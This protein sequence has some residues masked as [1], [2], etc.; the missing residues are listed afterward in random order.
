VAESENTFLPSKS[1][2]VVSWTSVRIVSIARPLPRS[3]RARQRNLCCPRPIKRLV[4]CR[5]VRLCWPRCLS[6]SLS[7]PIL[8]LRPASNTHPSHPSLDR[9]CRTGRRLGGVECDPRLRARGLVRKRGLGLVLLTRRTVLL[10][11]LDIP[12]AVDERACVGHGHAAKVG[13]E[14]SACR[15]AR[16][17]AL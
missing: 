3:W 12:H 2:H 13:H 15:V 4:R 5:S 9:G 6:L 16:K 10:V 1:T 8:L 7:W 11:R 17:V 14:M